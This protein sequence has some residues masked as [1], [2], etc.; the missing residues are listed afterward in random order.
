MIVLS[1]IEKV[2]KLKELA[3]DFGY[4][5][6]TTMIEEAVCDSVSPAICIKRGCDYTTDMEPDQDAGC[7][8]VCGG[9]TVQSALVL[10][11]MI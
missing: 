5:D 11:G 9:Q 3:A 6:T 4:D 2:A 7:C 1:A 8:E 10:A